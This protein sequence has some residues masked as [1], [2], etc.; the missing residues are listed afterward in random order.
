MVAAFGG[1][2]A[3]VQNLL[4]AG[5]DINAKDDNEGQTALM[6]AASGGHTAT[7]QALLDAGVNVDAKTKRGV[8]ALV[9]TEGKAEL[10]GGGMAG[11]L[12]EE[13]AQALGRWTE[14]VEILKKA[15]AKELVPTQVSTQ[16]NPSSNLW[17]THI[18]AGQQA[19]GQGDYIEADKHLLAALEEAENF[20]PND[21][22]IVLNLGFLAALNLVQ[23]KY[24][25]AESL[26]VRA[27]AI[28]EKAYGPEHPLLAS[29]PRQP[30]GG[31]PWP[32]E[33]CRGRAAYQTGACHQREDLR[34][35]A[36]SRGL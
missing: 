15:G 8:T 23:E 34:T 3:T 5:A 11:P 28:V 35:G 14:V 4:D 32:R 19:F 10:L 27:L 9:M 2:T 30:V 22:R 17:E 7:I 29:S 33:V 13:L 24:A 36:P 31:I 16:S 20:G 6:F 12:P 25:E 21:E 18:E 1:H 26:A